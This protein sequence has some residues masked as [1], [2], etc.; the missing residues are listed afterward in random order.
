MPNGNAD[1]GGAA[2]QSRFETRESCFRESRSFSFFFSASIS[3]A[4]SVNRIIGRA[5]PDREESK[6]REPS[7]ERRPTGRTNEPRRRSYRASLSV[8]RLNEAFDEGIT[9]RYSGTSF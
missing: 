5:T 1:D 4:D 7:S 9:G 2:R 8:R 6:F 3:P